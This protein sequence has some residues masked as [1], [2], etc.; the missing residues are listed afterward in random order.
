MT[1]FAYQRAQ[2]FIRWI[3]ELAVN[4]N[5]NDITTRAAMSDRSRNPA[6]ARAR[7]WCAESQP[8]A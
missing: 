6:S 1:Y 3:G 7:A 4:G 5:G 2:R 8:A